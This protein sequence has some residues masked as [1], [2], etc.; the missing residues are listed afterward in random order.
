M[1]VLF[2][3]KGSFFNRN[4]PKKRKPRTFYWN[5]LNKKV[6]INPQRS[7]LM[8]QV[9]SHRKGKPV[10]VAVRQKISKA[11][12]KTYTSGRTKSGRTIQ[13]KPRKS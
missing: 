13:R 2:G 8:T 3:G 12:K 6:L 9:M 1:P 5:S 7:R 11:L 4:K 10:P